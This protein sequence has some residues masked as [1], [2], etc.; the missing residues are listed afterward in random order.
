MNR[1]LSL[2]VAYVFL[3]TQAWALS[4]GPIYPGTGT[5]LTGTY[6]GVLVPD[7]PQTGNS[8]SGQ[9]LPSNITSIGLFSVGV[10][11]VG[12]A[13]GALIFFVNGDS[14]SGTISGIA[15]PGKGTFVGLVDAISNFILVD[16]N[17]PGVEFRIFAAGN[18]DAEIL[19]KGGTNSSAPGSTRLE[20]TAVV[21]VSGGG[22]GYDG[23]FTYL[24]DGYKQSDTATTTT[25]IPGT[26]T[27]G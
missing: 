10:P 22:Q 6:A 2:L 19:N 3:Q 21:N 8:L 16:P 26:G 20:G 27:G 25:T 24:V 12:I 13:S 4:G 9:P 15:D 11:D 17:F 14:Y 1:V 18:I 23:V 7:V 5:T